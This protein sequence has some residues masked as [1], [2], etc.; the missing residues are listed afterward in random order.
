MKRMSC[1][2]VAQATA[3]S[4]YYRRSVISRRNRLFP[5]MAGALRWKS[6][7]TTGRA[8]AANFIRAIKSISARVTLFGQVA[9]YVRQQSVDP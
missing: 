9:F 1:F 2:C 3:E 7:I 5:G 6:P 4:H 8:F